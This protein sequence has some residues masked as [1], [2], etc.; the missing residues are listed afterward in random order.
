MTLGFPSPVLMAFPGHATVNLFSRT[1]L[2]LLARRPLCFL[3][4]TF[5]GAS[6]NSSSPL[7]VV[8]QNDH[9]ADKPGAEASPEMKNL[10]LYS[11]VT[12]VEPSL[13]VLLGSGV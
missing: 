1:F 12:L 8:R 3:P 2:L 7:G 6:N 11:D 4:Q 9:V 13:L 5:L 10:A